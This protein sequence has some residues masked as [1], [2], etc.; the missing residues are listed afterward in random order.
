MDL[1]PGD[2]LVLGDTGIEVELVHKSGRAA[3]LRVAAP[4]TVSIVKSRAAADAAI[5]NPPFGR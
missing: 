3:R 1:Q 5:A 2:R 4:Q